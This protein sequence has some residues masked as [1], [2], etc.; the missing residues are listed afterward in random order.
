MS[1]YD[2]PPQGRS[3]RQRRRY[4]RKSHRLW[5][6]LLCLICLAAASALVLRAFS[7]SIVFFM[8]PSQALEHP[9]RPDQSI[10]LG[11]MVVAGSLKR[12]MGPDATPENRFDVTDGQKAVTVIY[13]GVLPDL[14]REG[15][16]V[17]AMGVMTADKT[18]QASEVL[19]KHDETYMPKEVAEALRKSGKWDPRFGK[20]PRAEEW[21]MMTKSQAQK[22]IAQAE[23]ASH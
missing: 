5:I 16:S 12:H 23:H 9:P 7:S 15:Q 4:A 11:G 17:I 19:A 18:L 20:P 1:E 13:R 2:A 10:R 21:D 14:F 8:A 6:M 22:S 3:P